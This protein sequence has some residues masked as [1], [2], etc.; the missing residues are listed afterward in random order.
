[1]RCSVALGPWFIILIEK[2]T[3]MTQLV[4]IELSRPSRQWGP[5]ILIDSDPYYQRILMVTSDSCE[6]HSSTRITTSKHRPG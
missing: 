5:H 2:I 6:L 4:A 1:M 3:T